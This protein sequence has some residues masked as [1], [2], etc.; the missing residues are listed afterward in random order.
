M[1]LQVSQKLGA[2][3]NRAQL[4]AIFREIEAAL[5]R[6]IFAG[7]VVTWNPGDIVDGDTDSTTATVPGAKVGSKQSVRVFPPYD[8]QG[9]QVTAHVSADNTVTIVLSNLTGSNVNLDS[10]EWGVMVEFF[11]P[12]T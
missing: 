4:A 2:E 1:S 9:L 10:G 8:L 6:I 7:D 12:V 5:N 3:Y 11:P